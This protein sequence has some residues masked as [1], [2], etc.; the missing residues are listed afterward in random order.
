MAKVTG[1][2]LL[3]SRIVF[4]FPSEERDY[5]GGPAKKTNGTGPASVSA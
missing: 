2:G 5:D 3:F 4:L 1:H